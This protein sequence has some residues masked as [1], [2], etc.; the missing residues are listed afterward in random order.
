MPEAAATG[1]GLLCASEERAFEFV[2]IV[3]SFIRFFFFFLNIELYHFYLM[4]M[5]QLGF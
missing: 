2:D 3:N 1:N 5:W 4:K